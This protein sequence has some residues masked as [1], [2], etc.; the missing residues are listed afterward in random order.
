[1]A[2][3][4]LRFEAGRLTRRRLATAAAAAVVVLAAVIPVIGLVGGYRSHDQSANRAADRWVAS[5]YEE[6]PPN[7]VLISWWSYST[8]LW[9]HRWILGNRPDIT[10]I[11]ERN[12]LD[13]GYRTMRRA[14]LAH[15]GQRPVYVVPPTWEYE[16]IVD[17][18]R[19]RSVPT[20]PGY[21]ELLE[22][23]GLRQ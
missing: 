4:S 23:E 8:P 9:Y 5:V 3:I 22:I 17:Q 13:D 20:Y 21:S 14:I 12:I 15:L 19:S 2:E 1:M 6:L 10:I 18:F 16:A 11:D 7:S